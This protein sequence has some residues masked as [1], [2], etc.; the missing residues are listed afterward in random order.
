M[1]HPDSYEN[2]TACTVGRLRAILALYPDDL[3]LAETLVIEYDPEI[4]AYSPARLFIYGE[5]DL[6]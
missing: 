1:T 3:E 4:D 5:D 2:P 6:K